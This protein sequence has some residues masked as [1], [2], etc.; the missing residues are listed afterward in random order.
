MRLEPVLNVRV[1][2]AVRMAIERRRRVGGRGGSEAGLQYQ[3]Y[4]TLFAIGSA[5]T[6]AQSGKSVIRRLDESS[7]SVFI[8]LRK[9][10]TTKKEVA[11]VT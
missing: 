8:K 11:K 1:L 5:I 7:D 2:A 6:M 10:P 4:K 9:R 3:R